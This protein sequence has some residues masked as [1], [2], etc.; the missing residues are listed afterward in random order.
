MQV[1]R[2]RVLNVA[3]PVCVALAATALSWLLTRPP[4]PLAAA[5]RLFQAA[6]FHLAAPFRPPHPRI[7]LIA[8]DD[9]TLDGFPYR[10]PVDRGFLA[11]LVDQLAKAEVAAIGLDLLFDQPTEPAKDAALQ[12]AMRQSAAPVVALS[13][14]PETPLSPAR[15]AFLDEFLSGVRTGIGN[16]AR[17]VFDDTVRTH[18]PLH[19][20]TGAP[21]FP[22][23]LARTLGVATPAEPFPIAWRR[24]AEGSVAAV[25]PAHVISLLPAEWLRGR[26]ALVGGLQPGV[27]EHRTQASAF[28]PRSFG[29]EIHAQVLAQLLDGRARPGDAVLRELLCIAALAGAGVLAGMLLTGQRLLLALGVLSLGWLAVAVLAVRLGVPPWP[30]LPPVLASVVAA[31]GARAWTGRA[32]R[33]DRAALR[34]LFARFL[35]APVAEALIGERE[36]FLAGGRPRPLEL[37]ATVLFSDVAGFTTI[38]ES[39]PPEPLVAWLDRY[40]DTMVPIVVAHDGVVLRFVG[41]GI[42][43]AFGVPVP[44]RDAEAIAADARNAARC[45]LAME[46]AMAEL[47]AAW[48]AEGMPEA[49]LRIGIHTGPMVAGSLGHGERMEYCLLGDTANVGARLEQL[50]KEHGG[51]GPGSCT[52]LLGDPTWRLLGGAMRGVRIGDLALRNRRA[53]LAAWRIDSRAVAAQPAEQES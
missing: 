19:P 21:S 17:E 8:I 35:G 49:G 13:A 24:T 20:V 41:D 51:T 25:Y 42:L 40:I 38:C 53:T 37:T 23:T 7:V 29:V 34:Q 12:A 9:A 11:A 4:M 52:I 44:R 5:E 39:L 31:G 46:Q 32:E 36:L 27:D 18:I 50:G 1:P 15:A 47:N 48:R 26:A 6:S 14:G 3:L 45:A 10:S 43:A 22:V 16:L 2:R 28:V 30:A 33:R